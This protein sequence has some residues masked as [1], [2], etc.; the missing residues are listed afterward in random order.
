MSKTRTSSRPKFMELNL[1]VKEDFQ[2][3]LFVAKNAK[4]NWPFLAS[5]NAETEDFNQVMN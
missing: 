3:L 1:R 5:L 2:S 4:M